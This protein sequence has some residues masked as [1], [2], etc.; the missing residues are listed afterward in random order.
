MKPTVP[1]KKAHLLHWASQGVQCTYIGRVCTVL[2]CFVL[3]CFVLLYCIL[4][5]YVLESADLTCTHLSFL[6]VATNISLINLDFCLRLWVLMVARDMSGYFRMFGKI[7]TTDLIF[8]SNVI[9]FSLRFLTSELMIKLIYFLVLW[10]SEIILIRFKE[11]K[12][13][14][15]IN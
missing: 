12:G 10:L 6:W 13:N 9:T 14:R 11:V 1:L 3:F 15:C 5:L 4:F 8:V 7:K 2:F